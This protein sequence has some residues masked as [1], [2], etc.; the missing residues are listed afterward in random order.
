MTPPDRWREAAREI[1]LAAYKPECS[2]N[3][4]S[5][6]DVERAAEILRRLFPAREEQLAQAE[7]LARIPVFKPCSCG[8]EGCTYDDRAAKSTESE[9]Q[10]EERDGK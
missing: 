5:S 2:R 3:D 7:V 8:R 1:K 4:S 6:F 9:R 10:K